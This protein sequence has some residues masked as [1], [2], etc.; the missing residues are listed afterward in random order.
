MNKQFLCIHFNKI[1]N[2]PLSG[3]PR[4]TSGRQYMERIF[5]RERA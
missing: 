3:T 4:L 5:L 1:D 2:I